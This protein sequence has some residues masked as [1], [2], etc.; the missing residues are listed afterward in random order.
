[1]DRLVQGF[2][3]KVGLQCVGDAP[4]QNLSREP[5]HN[6][7]Q[8]E[9][10]FAHRNVGDVGAPDLIWAGDPQ[11]AKQIGVGLVSL[12]GLAGVGFLIDRQ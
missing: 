1:M 4:G 6:G 3:A 10:A 5:V 12:R 11:P 2:E 7:H 9:V 8:I